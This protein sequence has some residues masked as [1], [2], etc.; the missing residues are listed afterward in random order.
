MQEETNLLGAITA[1][2]IYSS[3]ILIFCFRLIGKI[4]FGYWIGIPLILT[5]FP[6]IYLLLKA[7]QLDRSSL[8]YIQI[9]LMLIWILVELLSDYIL[10]IK[11]RQVRWAVISYVVLYFAGIG[12]MI[13]IAS[14]AGK[15]WA[16][17]AVILFF[18]TA[19]L[20]FF[21]RKVTGL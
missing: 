5:A 14:N 3:S 2:I 12:G 18:V 9:I 10:K 17:I 19:V 8:Y 15:A 13:G 21:Q 7:P 1:L 11:F 6:L 16:I 20:S 4:Q